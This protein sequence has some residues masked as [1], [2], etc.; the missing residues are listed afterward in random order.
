M[1]FFSQETG[2]AEG[3]R[4]TVQTGILLASATPGPLLAALM[5]G[6]EKALVIHYF[7]PEDGSTYDPNRMDGEVTLINPGD[8]GYRIPGNMDLDDSTVDIRAGVPLWVVRPAADGAAVLGI[9]KLHTRWNA[10]N[11]DFYDPISRRH[12]V[13]FLFTDPRMP[14]NQLPEGWPTPDEQLEQIKAAGGAIDAAPLLA[15]NWP[16]FQY[17][18]SRLRF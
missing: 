8:P 17:Q 15:P 11:I 7:G 4:R 12:A 14:L 1:A 16:D 3:I 10:A 2:L 6:E 13:R 18:G 5:D 9:G